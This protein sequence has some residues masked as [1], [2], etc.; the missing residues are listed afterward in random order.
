[1]PKIAP[2]A[3]ALVPAGFQARLV[4]RA[5]I[6][7]PMPQLPHGWLG[8]GN[9][10]QYHGDEDCDIDTENGLRHDHRIGLPLHP[11]GRFDA[12]E[13]RIL[14]ALRRFMLHAPLADLSAESKGWK[15]TTALHAICHERLSPRPQRRLREGRSSS[16]RRLSRGL[17]G[18]RRREG[19]SPVRWFTGRSRRRFLH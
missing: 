18:Q 13:G 4:E 2:E 16:R 5:V 12:L 6:R 19:V 11:G 8:D 14:A 10:G 9:A 17:R 1:M 3:P 7:S 15:L